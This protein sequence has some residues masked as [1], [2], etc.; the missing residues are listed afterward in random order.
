M[1][2]AFF[3][4]TD[5][6][7]KQDPC[8]VL[9]LADLFVRT[10][11]HH[12]TD[13]LCDQNKLLSSSRVEK[14]PIL[15]CRSRCSGKSQG[16]QA[17]FMQQAKE[18]SGHLLRPGSAVRKQ[19]TSREKCSFSAAAHDRRENAQALTV[20]SRYGKAQLSL[21]PSFPQLLPWHRDSSELVCNVTPGQK[22]RC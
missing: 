11:R 12:P 18:H 4:F 5:A 20:I 14:K 21:W 7:N 16:S 13:C 8:K 9:N 19:V 10:N 22:Q 2:A 17:P 6:W 15:C 1:V 3:L